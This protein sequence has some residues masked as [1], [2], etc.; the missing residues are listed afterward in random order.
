MNPRGRPSMLLLLSVGLS[1]LLALATNVAADSLPGSL[2]RNR[3][4]V[5]G[6]VGLLLATTAAVELWQRR[7]S[8]R[9]ADRT[10]LT[11]RNLQIG[12]DTR[13]WQAIL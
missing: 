7:S 6:A 9:T 4:L 3:P 5:W 8:R 10:T 12:R 1:V 11:N 13:A 2:V